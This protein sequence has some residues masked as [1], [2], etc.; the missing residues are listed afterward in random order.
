MSPAIRAVE[1]CSPWVRSGGGC[2][3]LAKDL[4][5]HLVLGSGFL[6]CLR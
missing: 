5:G 1:F 2:C 6:V 4:T 3:S